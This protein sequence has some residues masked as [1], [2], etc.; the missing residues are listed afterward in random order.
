M[1]LDSIKRFCK[2]QPVLL[3]AFIAAVLTI[4]FIP[5]DKEYFNY[6]NRTVLIQLFC[7]MAAVSGFRS[8]GIFEKVTELML[9]KV[10]NLRRLG[11]IFTL[12]CFFSSMLVT[13]DVVLI[14]FVPLTLIVYNNINDEKSRIMT[15][16]LE[17]AGANLGSMLTPFG[18]PQNLFIYDNYHL[19]VC[20]FL[21]TMLPSG[22]ISLLMLL[23]LNLT[24]PRTPCKTFTKEKS[25]IDKKKSIIYL[26]LFIMCLLTVFRVIPDLWCLAITIIVLLILDI[27]LFSRIDYGLLATFVCFF[28]FVGNIAR[29]ESVREFFSEL[30]EGS[31]SF[32]LAFTSYK[33]RSG[34]GNVVRIYRKRNTAASWRKFRRL[35]NSNC[36]ACKFNFLSVLPQVRK[37]AVSALYVYF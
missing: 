10:E 18:N 2:S 32:S 4:I 5:P 31:Y 23:L 9:N 16:V 35:R 14:T 11:I 12:I 7:L 28:V 29:M 34:S 25:C 13:N 8:I 26:A 19:S 30:L 22:I 36:I 1:I 3:T 17:T 15:I 6:C 24:I 20:D 27:R 33:Q 37:C 21:K